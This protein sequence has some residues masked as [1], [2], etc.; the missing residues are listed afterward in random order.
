MSA[1]SLS[2]RMRSPGRPALELAAKEA[3][4]RRSPGGAPPTERPTRPS[5]SSMSS[6]SGCGDGRQRCAE[7]RRIFFFLVPHKQ[8][9][10][11]AGM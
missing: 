2:P 11:K 4:G 8:P 6:I 5:T 9:Q 7:P 1:D 3:S 10:R